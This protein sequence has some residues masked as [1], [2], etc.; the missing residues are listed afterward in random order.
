[1][2]TQQQVVNQLLKLIAYQN[3]CTLLT[4]TRIPLTRQNSLVTI[5]Y[6]NSHPLITV[7]SSRGGRGCLFIRFIPDSPQILLSRIYL[8]LLM[9]TKVFR[10]FSASSLHVFG[11]EFVAI[12]VVSGLEASVWYSVLQVLRRFAHMQCKRRCQ[13]CFANLSN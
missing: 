1:M 4:L 12:A 5:S 13:N 7:I 2:I 8:K 6:S 9:H 10:M 3:I 11:T